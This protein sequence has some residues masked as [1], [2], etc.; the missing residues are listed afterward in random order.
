MNEAVPLR[1]NCVGCGA[2]CRGRYVPLTLDETRQWLDRGHRVGVLIEAFAKD[3]PVNPAERFDHN[4]RRAVTVRS[5]QA[6]IYLSVVFAGD[7]LSD[8]PNLGPDN[9][10]TIY[11]ERPL[12]CR[13]YP[14]EINPFIAL[15]PS[16]KD[17]PS[18]AWE[19]TGDVV[20]NEAGEVG[21]DIAR[22]IMAS[23]QADA[24]DALTKA[25]IC[26]RLG[27]DVAGWK[28]DGFAV[29]QPDI[30]QMQAALMAEQADAKHDDRV[31]T[32]AWAVQIRDAGL[33]DF[34]N[35]AGVQIY[36]DPEPFDPVSPHI[37]V[38]VQ[39]G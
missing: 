27:F 32:G 24:S 28:G 25:R 2:C 34:A 23:R 21:N 4:S 30:A 9:M 31:G 11:S 16:N 6:E 19:P 26:E 12:V 17:C 8:C 5:G 14:M 35:S 3:D 37:F 33:Y 13:I 10:C 20:I 7:A 29:Y 22:L 18:E 39:G 15:D 36:C 1:F 38:P